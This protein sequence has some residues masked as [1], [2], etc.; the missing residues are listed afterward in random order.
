[1]SRQFRAIILEDDQAIA[2]A[3]HEV[4]KELGG[5]KQKS[6]EEN[7]DGGNF[8]ILSILVV[9]TAAAAWFYVKNHQ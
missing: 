2:Q 3:V 8:A 7:N 4:E 5:D 9:A 1:M 6:S